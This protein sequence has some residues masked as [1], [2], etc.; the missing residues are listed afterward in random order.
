[1]SKFIYYIGVGASYGKRNSGLKKIC[2]ATKEFVEK[3]TYRR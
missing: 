2:N 3:K 1:M